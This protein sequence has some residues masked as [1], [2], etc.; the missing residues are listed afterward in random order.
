MTLPE[1]GGGEVKAPEIL[2]E[3]GKERK[4]FLVHVVERIVCDASLCI[5]LVCAICRVC[6]VRVRA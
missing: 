2:V 1:V 4:D 3:G 6:R 5:H